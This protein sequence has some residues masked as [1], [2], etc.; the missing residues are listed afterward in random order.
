MWMRTLPTLMDANTEWRTCHSGGE[1]SHYRWRE[2]WPAVIGITASRP[3]WSKGRV[4]PPLDGR[5]EPGQFPVVDNL[6]HAAALELD[7]A[8]PFELR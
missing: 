8:A 5:R 1:P 6:D 2:R 3:P 4:D 7:D